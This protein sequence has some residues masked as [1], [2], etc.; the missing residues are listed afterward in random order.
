MCLLLFCRTVHQIPRV[1]LNILIC[2]F[3]SD[4]G[5][6]IIIQDNYKLLVRAIADHLIMTR[7][8]EDIA[9]MP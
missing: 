4:E 8:L 2:Y 7:R 5:C 6:V 3:C 1:L 9:K